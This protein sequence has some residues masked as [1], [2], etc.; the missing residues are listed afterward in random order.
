MIK[1]TMR[2]YCKKCVKPVQLM[3]E[4]VFSRESFLNFTDIRVEINYY[5]GECHVHIRT[6]KVEK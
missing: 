2:S 5:C 3:S 4:D 1:T 6:I